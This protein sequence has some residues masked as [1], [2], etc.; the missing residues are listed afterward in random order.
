MNDN[1]FYFEKKITDDGTCLFNHF[2]NS[3]EDQD[4]K[5]HQGNTLAS[6]EWSYLT[7]KIIWIILPLFWF[8]RRDNNLDLG[9]YFNKMPLNEDKN[10]NKW[11]VKFD[12]QSFYIWL[13]FLTFF[14]DNGTRF[15]QILI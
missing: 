14:V 2:I 4:F 12:P 11:I 13:T 9:F 15:F 10:D 6:L 3:T 7:L 1:D 5:F 8:I